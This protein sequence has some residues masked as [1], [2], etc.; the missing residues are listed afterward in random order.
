MS[1]EA[2]YG[3]YETRS[4]QSNFSI[5]NLLA[6]LRESRAARLA[7]LGGSVLA[8][9]LGVEMFAATDTSM[10]NPN[11][12]VKCDIASP[13]FGPML[14][15]DTKDNIEANCAGTV[16]PTSANLAI[17]NFYLDHS[18]SRYEVKFTAPTP[19]GCSPVGKEIITVGQQL[20]DGASG[21]FAP[22]GKVNTMPI[23]NL[24]KRI[25]APRPETTVVEAPY[26]CNT[27]TAGSAV[28]SVVTVKWIPKKGWSSKGTVAVSVPGPSRRV[29]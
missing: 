3:G 5:G 12:W 10:A 2:D 14:C 29:C 15:G 26:S 9:G 19:G 22:N 17:K 23:T 8:G 25:G 28:R 6:S 7:V 4:D 16:K 21:S 20:R 13:N 18:G 11:D 27:L 1:I 24:K